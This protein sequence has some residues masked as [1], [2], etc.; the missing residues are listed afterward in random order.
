MWFCAVD[1]DSCVEA[2]YGSLSGSPVPHGI[3]CPVLVFSRAMRRPFYIMAVL[4]R[5][6]KCIVAGDYVHYFN[7]RGVKGSARAEAGKSETAEN[8]MM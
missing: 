3:C 4:K 8:Q 5:K 7:D 6:M 1:L 2:P